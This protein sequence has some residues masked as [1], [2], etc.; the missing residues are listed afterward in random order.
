MHKNWLLHFLISQIA[1]LA[2]A[3]AVWKIAHPWV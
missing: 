1:L 2:L 3:A